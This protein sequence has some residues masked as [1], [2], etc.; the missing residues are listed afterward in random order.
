LL[1]LKKFIALELHDH[2]LFPAPPIS[3]HWAKNCDPE[4]IGWVVKYSDCFE[5]TR[6]IVAE[7]PKLEYKN[8]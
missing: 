7:N 2:H 3:Q 4:A 8:F 5:L 1:I 6:V